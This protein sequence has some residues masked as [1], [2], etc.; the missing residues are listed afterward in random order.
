MGL[1]YL[2]VERVWVIAVAYVKD[3]FCLQHLQRAQVQGVN[4][5]FHQRD[6]TVSAT[7]TLI[8]SRPSTGAE[9]VQVNFT[10]ESVTPPDSRYYLSNKLLTLT[11]AM[12]FKSKM[13]CPFLIFSQ[14][15][16]LN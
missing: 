7:S 11:L 6:R 14:P 4:Q 1:E 13:S 8:E 5:L 9:N 16:Y 2:C 15:D 10:V 3:S 12:F